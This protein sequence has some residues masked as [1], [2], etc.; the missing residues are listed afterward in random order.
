M[1]ERQLWGGVETPAFTGEANKDRLKQKMRNETRKTPWKEVN[2]HT[3]G[4][5]SLVFGERG[6][7]ASDLTRQKLSTENKQTVM[8]RR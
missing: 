3:M 1:H 2:Y 6:S 4:K 5:Y 7:R 8:Q